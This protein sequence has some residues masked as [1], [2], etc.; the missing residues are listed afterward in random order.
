MSTFR[1]PILFIQRLCRIAT[2]WKYGPNPD[3]EAMVATYIY[4]GDTRAA[5]LF[6]EM[7]EAEGGESTTEDMT[8]VAT[9]DGDSATGQLPDTFVPN[10][11]VAV[12]DMA[13]TEGRVA[14]TARLPDVMGLRRAFPEIA[15]HR[16][17]AE[18]NELMEKY[19]I[20]VDHAT[21]QV[22]S[23]PDEPPE[24]PPP[25]EGELF[26]RDIN[27][28]TEKLQS[29][30]HRYIGRI[31]GAKLRGRS[32]DEAERQRI[33]KEATIEAKRKAGLPPYKEVKDMD[34]EELSRLLKFLQGQERRGR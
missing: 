33:F 6:R 7:I 23:V 25:L 32:T 15:T 21:G 19:G 3:D 20:V 9:V 27:E 16:T 18:T 12:E 30:I 34:T 24:S 4:P 2:I 11:N 8:S 10:E 29:A 28:E 1:T 26:V 17:E 31:G 22:V 5:E 14:S 13:D